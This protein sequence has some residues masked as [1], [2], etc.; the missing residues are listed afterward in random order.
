MIQVQETRHIST[1][2]K[3]HTEVLF[4]CALL[5]H[6]FQFEKHLMQ[7]K[8]LFLKRSASCLDFREFQDI[9]DQCEKVFTT[10]FNNGQVLVLLV[11]EI[12]LLGHQLREA[13]NHVERCA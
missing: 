1:P 7:V 9:V 11:A 10:T 12:G 4:L 3:D 2:L 13:Q 8:I 5:E 6:F